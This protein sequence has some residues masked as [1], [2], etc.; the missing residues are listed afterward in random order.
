MKEHS[1]LY[2]IWKNPM[3]RRNFIVGKLE[4]LASGYA[5]EYCN[6]YKEA[7]EN[8]W[9]SIQAFSKGKKI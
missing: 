3:S 8:G 5:F 4:K 9:V 6:D 7:L 2:L 1:F